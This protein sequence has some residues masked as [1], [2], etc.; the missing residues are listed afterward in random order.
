MHNANTWLQRYANLDAPLLAPNELHQFNQLSR[1]RLPNF[2]FDLSQYPVHVFATVVYDLILENN[3]PTEPRYIEGKAVT[4]AYYEKLREN[5]NL[6]KLQAS[7]QVEY[8]YTLQRTNIRTFPTN[9][10]CVKSPEDREFDRFQETAL[11]PA[12]PLI[13]LHQSADRLWHFVQAVNYRGWVAVNCIAVSKD[14][15]LWLKYLKANNFL[16]VTGNRL[17]LGEEPYLPHFSGL[18]FA[19]GAKLPLVEGQAIPALVG[20]RTPVDCHV[21]WLPVS[22]TENSLAFQPALVPKSADVHVGYL[23]F[24]RV[25]VIKQAFKLQGDRYGWGGLFGSRDCSALVL[26]IYR[27]VGLILARNAGE[28]AQGAGTTISLIEKSHAD[29]VDILRSLPPGS[30]L[31]FP[32]HVMFFLGEHEERFY[33]LHAIN[34]CGDPE[35]PQPDGTLAP[36][37]LNS[38]LVTDLSLHRTNG[39]TL[40]DA[41]TEAHQIP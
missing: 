25:N 15:A 30:T 9:D 33:V 40:F 3:F 36:L 29:R 27:S 41:L 16:V 2:L 12:E 34:A 32:G 5:L 37:A 38:I 7:L 21:V 35:R 19:M 17:V 10:F 1:E 13:V 18:T 8:G 39:I 14:R 24:S 4:L 11:D 20:N 28:Q 23:P 26:D 22:D 6:E 31:H